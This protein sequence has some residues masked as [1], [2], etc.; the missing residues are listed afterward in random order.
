MI[1]LNSNINVRLF[2]LH[3]KY[4]ITVGMSFL[5][6]IYIGVL[7]KSN[8]KYF[9]LYKYINIPKHDVTHQKYNRGPKVGHDPV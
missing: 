1:E 5:L 6:Y 4:S 8:I 7:Q 9:I 3:G 2:Q